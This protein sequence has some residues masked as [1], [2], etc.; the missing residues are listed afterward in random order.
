VREHSIAGHKSTPPKRR[1]E[2]PAQGLTLGECSARDAAASQD[3]TRR[4]VRSAA[5]AIVRSACSI[6]LGESHHLPRMSFCGETRA[7]L[8][9]KWW[10]RE[11][12][13]GRSI[14]PMVTLSVLVGAFVRAVPA[15]GR[16][17]RRLL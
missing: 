5:T 6:T 2:D 1:A 3:S 10:T 13:E 17:S 9:P 11:G 12:I 16:S 8:A 4:V 15:R 14:V 7:A